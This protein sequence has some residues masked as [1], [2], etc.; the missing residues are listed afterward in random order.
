M[1]CSMIQGG[2]RPITIG[3]TPTS[4]SSCR[5]PLSTHAYVPGVGCVACSTP[6]TTGTSPDGLTCACASGYYRTQGSV[7]ACTPCLVT[8]FVPQ[9]DGGCSPRP[10][11]TQGG[12]G[13]VA[14]SPR[15][16]TSHCQTEVLQG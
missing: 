12:R 9:S 13:G 5:C 2:L 7:T 14:P 11:V 16:S 8:G 3:A 10:C 15:Q 4:E 6:S 1:N